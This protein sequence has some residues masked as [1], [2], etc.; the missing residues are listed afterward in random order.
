MVYYI[1][2]FHLS[3]SKHINFVALHK[4]ADQLADGFPLIKKRR[5]LRRA[6]KTLKYFSLALVAL[7]L[8]L[9]ILFSAEIISLK[10]L[11]SQTIYGQANLEQAVVLSQHDKLSQAMALALTA[12]NNFNSS[13]SQL[14]EIK[15]DYFVNKFSW[16]SGQLSNIENLLVTA[17]FLSK[18]VYGG[19]SFG[20]SLENLLVG[21]QKLNFSK[22][23]PEEKRRVLSKIF[24]STPELNGIKADLDLAYLNLEQVDLAG[25]LFPLQEKISQIK[26]QIQAVRLILDKA[27]PLSQLLP[28]LAGYPNQVKYLVMLQ[29]NDEL[30]PTGGFLGTYGILEIKDGEITNFNTHDIYHLDMP[31]KDK[32]NVIPPEPIKKY[33]APKWYLRDANWSPDWPTAARQIDWF[34]QKESRLNPAAEKISEFDGVIALTPELITDFLAIIGSV[35][36][37]GQSYNQANFQDL[38]QYRVEK[39]Y[40]DLGVSSWNR[41]E[42]ISELAKELKNRIFD[43]PPAGWFRVMN[44]IL[45]NLAKKNLLIYL[46]DNQL[47]DITIDNGW[48]GELKDTAGDYVMVVDA[49]LGA[50]KT[51]A[52]LNRSLQYKVNQ[53]PNGWFAKLTIGYAHNGKTDWK[54]STY[55][56]YTRIYVPLGSELIKINDYKLDDITVGNELG[57]TWFGFYLEVQ[58]GEIKNLTIEYKLPALI[59]GSKNYELYL[60]KQPGKEISEARVD[61][62]FLND[63][64]SYSPTSLSTQKVSPTMIKWAG[65]LN[66]DRSFEVDF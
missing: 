54:T 40:V 7:G 12:Q 2:M 17:Q 46:A 59:N 39:G 35:T 16:L 60:Q 33:L 37:E 36:V 62:A 11:Y 52:V 28:A 47:Q 21:D 45:D 44:V 57:K 51:D 22:F 61:L 19:A 1:Q 42:V 27:V 41:K 5:R 8:I 49:N 3:K 64:E 38:L 50:L 53:S 48:G 30:R 56:S 14:A 4:M 31:V 55:K 66:I 43:L 34:Y 65:D 6:Y 29:N 9:L 24:E 15:N 10:E 20:Q 58:P 23:S 18:A 25:A 26:D 13:I 32:V 63:I